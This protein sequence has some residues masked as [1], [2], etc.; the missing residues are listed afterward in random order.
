MNAH[1][2]IQQV[3]PRDGRIRFVGE[4]H[5]HTPDAS[6]AGSWQLLLVLRGTPRGTEQRLRYDAP[7]DGVRFDVSLPVDDIAL[8]GLPAATWDLHLCSGDGPG[9]L[10]LRAGRH[11]DGIR[12]K[13][14]IMV[15]PAQSVTTDEDGTVV[16]PFYTVNS[17]LSVECVPGDIGPYPEEIELPEHVG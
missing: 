4:L 3:W 6:A 11:L 14:T 9:E 1:A 12:D 13:K 5:G 7:L 17:N 15:Y 8:D 16:R 2:E 10:R